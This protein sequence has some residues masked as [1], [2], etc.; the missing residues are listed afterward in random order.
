MPNTLHKF[1]IPS[2]PY[3]DVEYYFQE[4]P[5]TFSPRIF[6]PHVHEYIEFYVL[7]EGDTS[8]MVEHNLYKLQAGDV[9][10]SRPNE[11]HNCILNTHSVHK[12]ACLYVYPSCEF[13]FADFIS[14]AFGENNLISPSVSEKERLLSLYKNLQNATQQKDDHKRLYVTLE[15]LDIYRK[16][17]STDAKEQPLPALLRTILNDINHNFAHITRLQYFTERYFI[18]QSTLHRLFQ[19]HLHTSP[20]MYLETKKL[21][22]SRIL[23]KEGKSVLQASRLAGFPDCSNYIRLFKKRFGTTPKLYQTEY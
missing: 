20:K 18:S 10:L 23:L 13:L 11:M 3:L 7:L 16:N 19:T 6:P 9:I 21:A 14:G 5:I 12:H 15:I 8:F 4:G 1:H 2:I 22:Y 17:L